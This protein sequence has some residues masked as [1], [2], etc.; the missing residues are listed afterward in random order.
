MRPI[1]QDPRATEGRGGPH[2]V[3]RCLPGRARIPIA[4]LIL[5]C[6]P[7]T[8]AGVPAQAWAQSP[9]PP[10][11]QLLA[12]PP[13]AHALRLLGEA[14]A[15]V[16]A[17][18]VLPVDETALVQAALKGML[19]TLDGHSSYLTP[20]EFA[21]LGE[22]L[23]AEFAGIGL[24]IAVENGDARAVSPVDGGPSARAGIPVGAI[25][26][27]IDG[28]S[29]HGL[30]LPQVVA[31]LRGA[32]GT[33]VQLTIVSGAQP[34][35]RL[36]LI[37]E[38]IRTTSVHWRAAGT[39]GYVRI[40]NF[41]RRTAVDL[42]DAL[43]KLRRA[44]PALSGVVLD[45]RNN[46]GGLF[47]AAVSVSSRFLPAGRIVVR[48]GRKIADAQAI[49][50]EPPGD[51]L[52]GLPLAV[53]VNGGSASSSEIVAGAL[54]DNQ[55]AVIVGMTTWGKGLVQTLI[56]LGDG[57]DGALSVTAARYYT[58]S[59]RSIQKL[60]IVPDLAV[61]RSEDEVRLALDASRS[62]SEATLARAIDNESGETRKPPLDPE[63]PAPQGGDASQA[64]PLFAS[65]VPSNA[66]LLDDL[67]IRRAIDV[68]TLGGVAQARKLRPMPILCTAV[69][70]TAVSPK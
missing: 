54:Q 31:R 22:T 17:N 67:Q 70:P 23:N 1:R 26:R 62:P 33:P 5:T 39:L 8:T 64:P 14:L 7:V 42:V 47:D 4:A 65:S 20:T 40:T 37:R 66:E 53:I 63:I 68:L 13:D 52:G 55:R 61:A 36:T 11:A 60:G 25:I 49:A 34:P 48:K 3:L 12:D 59:G 9:A 51:V 21:A 30:G 43:G 28:Q 56:P 45:L 29:A 46:P 69:T 2:R 16:R 18:H 38:V 15:Q 24:V 41:D 35:R 6:L 44:I 58:P 57:R 10:A 27:E 19:N 50:V 32:V